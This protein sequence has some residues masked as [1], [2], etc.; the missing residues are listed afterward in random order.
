AISADNQRRRHKGALLTR[1]RLTVQVI[2]PR[3]RD[4]VLTTKPAGD[5]VGIK[6]A[7][8]ASVGTLPVARHGKR[9]RRLTPPS[10]QISGGDR[11]LV[12]V[13][14]VD[15]RLQHLRLA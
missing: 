9:L 14:S 5:A 13:D 12:T 4:R 11:S 1:Q 2:H 6:D 7:I 3:A 10:L 8:E 15:N